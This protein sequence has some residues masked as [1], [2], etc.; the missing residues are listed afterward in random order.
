MIINLSPVRSDSRISV[1]VNGNAISIN[2]EVFDF[3]P[4][5]DGDTLPRQAINS[6]WFADDVK[7]IDGVLQ[8]ELVFPHGAYADEAARFPVPITVI[9]D[10]PVQLPD[11][12]HDAPLPEFS[13][14]VIE[15][16]PVE[17]ESHE[18]D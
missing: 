17:E 6:P 15:T 4:L 12:G 8:V 14:P 10:G 2:E 11:G 9:Q 16:E 1:S 18:H 7:R 5:Q 3:S 13:G